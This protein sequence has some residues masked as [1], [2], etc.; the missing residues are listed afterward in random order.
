MFVALL[1]FLFDIAQFRLQVFELFDRRPVGD[2]RSQF[3]NGLM[4]SF[5]VRF[6]FI[7]QQIQFFLVTI[8]LLVQL[9][10]FG[11]LSFLQLFEQILI[12]G[13]NVLSR[14]VSLKMKFFLGVFNLIVHRQIIL[15]ERVDLIC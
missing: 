11:F 7:D 9:V 10:L 15:F 5:A 12:I 3:L 13:S 6:L 4:D 2:R 8:R 14:F 1:N